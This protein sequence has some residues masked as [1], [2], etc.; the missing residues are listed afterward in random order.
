MQSRAS[1]ASLVGSG[2]ILC[3]SDGSWWELVRVEMVREPGGVRRDEWTRHVTVETPPPA[4]T[5]LHL[6]PPASTTCLHLPPPASTCLHHL[7]PPAS[8]CLHLP[9][10]AAQEKRDLHRVADARRAESD[11]F[12]SELKRLTLYTEELV[13]S[14]ES[15][16]RSGVRFHRE[17]DKERTVRQKQLM[18][19][20][21][22]A[23][24]REEHSQ[25]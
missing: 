18:R 3:E 1:Q 2:G 21:R 11:R 17:L 15:V 12:E 4:S 13:G 8:T 22:M 9:S 5:C 23:A 20:R 24:E 16:E 6:P 7:P 14:K 10:F 19:R 25:A